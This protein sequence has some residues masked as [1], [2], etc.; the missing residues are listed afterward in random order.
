MR[1]D[2]RSHM[3]R[4]KGHAKLVLVVSQAAGDDAADAAGSSAALRV[5][6]ISLWNLKSRSG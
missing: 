3:R 2:P 5:E 1:Q 4:C 6:M